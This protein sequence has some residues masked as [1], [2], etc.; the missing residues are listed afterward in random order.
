[1]VALRKTG[2]VE[3]PPCVSFPV[4]DIGAGGAAM[5]ERGEGGREQ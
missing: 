4:W 1:M 2:Q 3:G 5:G